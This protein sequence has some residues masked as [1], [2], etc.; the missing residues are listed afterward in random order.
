MKNPRCAD[1]G[2]LALR[3]Q[4]FTQYFEAGLEYR[5]SGEPNRNQYHPFPVCFVRAANLKQEMAGTKK[6]DFLR[7]IHGERPCAEFI[8]WE[9]GMSPKEHREMRME[10]RAEAR[11][12]EDVARRDAWEK[13]QREKDKQRDADWR[14]LDIEAR[15][16]DRAQDRKWA[17]IF[18]VI[19]AIIGLFFEPV[20]G[21]LNKVLGPAPERE[22]RPAAPVA[23]PAQPAAD[24]K[25]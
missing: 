18:I 3:D 8:P 23:P 7:V 15:E 6:D 11:Y 17:I 9:M 24:P 14:R 25:K 20:K 13:E 22:A 19:A 4:Q 21:W 1:C 10:E 16:R 12:R 2:F 5:D